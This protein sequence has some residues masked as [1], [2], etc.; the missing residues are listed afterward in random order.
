[1]LINLEISTLKLY[2][3]KSRECLL[4]SSKLAL[5]TALSLSLLYASTSA[6]SW[7]PGSASQ[8]LP[9]WSGLQSD[10]PD[11][12]KKSG[13]PYLMARSIAYLTQIKGRSYFN[14][15]LFPNG[16][17]LVFGTVFA[18]KYIPNDGKDSVSH[19]NVTATSGFGCPAGGALGRELSGYECS[20]TD[21]ASY[22][23]FL[24]DRAVVHWLGLAPEPTP[25]PYITRDRDLITNFYAADNTKEKASI[26]LGWAAHMVQDMTNPYHTT[27]DTTL[28]TRYHAPYED[29]FDESIERGDIKLPL[30]TWVASR[31]GGFSQTI[32]SATNAPDPGSVFINT[33]PLQRRRPSAIVRDNRDHSRQ[34]LEYIRHTTCEIENDLL[35]LDEEGPCPG[36]FNTHL[37]QVLQVQ[38]DRAVKTVAELI[39]TFLEEVAPPEIITPVR[40]SAYNSIINIEVKKNKHAF[41]IILDAKWGG[42]WHEDVATSTTQKLSFNVASNNIPEGNMELRVRGCYDPLPNRACTD[43]SKPVKVIVDRTKPT[44]KLTTPTANA[45]FSNEMRVMAHS[46]DSRS[47]SRLTTMIQKRTKEGGSTTGTTPPTNTQILHYGYVAIPLS[48]KPAKTTN[49]KPTTKNLTLG[50]KLYKPAKL[51]PKNQQ[52]IKKQLGHMQPAAPG[53]SRGPLQGP[54]KPNKPVYEHGP[55]Y[56]PSRDFVWETIVENNLANAFANIDTSTWPA[57]MISLRARACD[58]AGNCNV[59]LPVKVKIDRSTADIVVQ[60]ITVGNPSIENNGAS[61]PITV[62]IKNTG[63]QNI[64]GYS[65]QIKASGETSTVHFNNGLN[66]SS[67]FLYEFTRNS[68]PLKCGA[69]VSV[70]AV[71]DAG[72]QELNLSNNSLLEAKIC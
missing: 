19:Y 57:G 6:F 9:S 64:S 50:M 72:N 22:A 63:G 12:A 15:H 70:K 20:Y 67:E 36:Y 69:R 44:V 2:V 56:D 66:G 8:P 5:S 13:H 33:I 42:Q 41:K 39:D 55:L 53:T 10:L 54:L 17:Y 30:T 61:W 3:K 26:Y 7:N 11:Y 16:G 62:L 27:N 60:K 23:D 4:R 38:G 52:S 32:A 43:V 49:N 35:E 40:R 37:G 58:D 24:Y 46:K 34:F 59:S 47:A 29:A 28:T 45:I 31:N 25:A 1:M 18:D 71:L 21:A 65:L 14:E 68:N 48:E 51:A